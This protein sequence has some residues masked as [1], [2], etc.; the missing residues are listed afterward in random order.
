MP[1]ITAD[2][3]MA[4]KLAGATGISEVHD[5]DGRVLGVFA[6]GS[7]AKAR[8]GLHAWL[9]L[10][11]KEIQ[12]RKAAGGRDYTFQEVLEHLNS[13]EATCTNTR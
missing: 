3:T 6:P 2:P 10:D 9:T 13:L 11:T 4:T 1:I 12:R 7:S 5:A 8:L